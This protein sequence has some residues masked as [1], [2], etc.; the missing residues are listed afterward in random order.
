MIKNRNIVVIGIQPWDIEIGSNC[1][2]I[3]IEFAKDNN[4]LYVNSP[5]DR[6]SSLKDKK[7]PKVAK[8]L[9]VVKGKRKALSQIDDRLWEFNPQTITESINR[10]PSAMVFDNLNKINSRRFGREIN[11]AIEHLKMENFILFNDSSMFLGLYL[12]KYLTSESYIYYIRDNLV[13]SPF[14]YWNTHGKRI[15]P[16]LISKA[17]AVVTN[18][19]YYAEYAK[20]YNPDSYMVGQGCDTSLFDF[21]TREIKTATE[22]KNISSPVI[23][24]V[25]NLAGIRLDIDL[26]EHIV[27]SKPAWQLVLV[28]PEDEAF[29]KSDLHGF[30]NVHF[31][32]SKPPDSLPEFISGFDVCINP[33][34]LNITTIGNY[35]RKIDEYL[36][37]GKPVV[38]TYTKAMEYFKDFTYLGKTKEDYVRLIS[39]ALEENTPEVAMRRRDYA[40]THS[41]ENNVKAIYDVMETSLKNEKTNINIV[42]S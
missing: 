42:R 26:L 10:I 15:E 21:K 8:R 33:Q 28:G 40:L 9:E 22:L 14:P 3:A 34:V 11:K 17:N 23:G 16:K 20:Q 31:L 4:V 5:L 7:S 39:R 12:D 13:N 2:N 29:K 27:R 19:L 37:M 32:G 36:A 38:A 30:P 41:W 1:K 18:S 24:Y 6:I 35:P 25:G